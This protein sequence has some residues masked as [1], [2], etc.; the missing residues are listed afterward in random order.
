MVW[1]I[2]APLISALALSVIIVVIS[3][4]LYE[5]VIPK[6][7]KRNRTLAALITTFLAMFVILAPILLITSVVVNE[8]LLI[9]ENPEQLSFLTSLDEV[10]A[11]LQKIAPANFNID[12]SHYLNQGAQ[13]FVGSLGAVFAGAAHTILLLFVA[14]IGS[15]YF[16]RDGSQFT[17][18]LIRYSPLPDNKD[19]HILKKL[20]DS[21]RGVVVGVVLIA[22]IQ[23]VLTAA[24]LFIAGFERAVLWGTVAAFCA[25][26][27][28]VGTAI[29]LVPAFL[30][31]IFTGNYLWA[32]FVAVWGM[33]VVGLIDNILAPYL[34][35]RRSSLHPFLVLLSVLGGVIVF[36][37]IGFIVGPMVMSLFLVLL[38][39]Y[40]THISRGKKSPTE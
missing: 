10:E 29:V 28:S 4:P 25:L 22:I 9:A 24:G 3:Y 5:K 40:S 15:F 26:V 31:L 12:I 2:I 35:S 14:F 30:Y 33:L 16:F 17:K 7:P 36:G 18:N 34:I 39:L 23:G 20:S 27:P 38:E 13:W 8:A 11:L 37:P 32:V 1:Q 21:I 6:M 19:G